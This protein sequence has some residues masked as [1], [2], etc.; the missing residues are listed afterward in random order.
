MKAK[1]IKITALQ[2]YAGVAE[3]MR[4][5]LFLKIITPMEYYEK[6]TAALKT[7]M[8]QE[9]DQTPNKCVD[10]L[11]SE[12]ENPLKRPSA[13]SLIDIFKELK[14]GRPAADQKYLA[15]CIVE[16]EQGQD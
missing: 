9:N 2:W 6:L 14:F 16:L 11:T 4:N 12:K 15:K 10:E 13:H 3:D 7:A 1:S 8:E 5:K